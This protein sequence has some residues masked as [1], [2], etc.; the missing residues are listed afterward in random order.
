MLKDL[1]DDLIDEDKYLRFVNQKSW[2]NSILIRFTANLSMAY[3][4]IKIDELV[5]NIGRLYYIE[6]LN[7]N[8]PII[9]L[10]KY[11]NSIGLFRI[12]YF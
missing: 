3:V 7:N 2:V 9:M 12:F 4:E 5:K 6:M 8:D 1:F 10:K 11:K